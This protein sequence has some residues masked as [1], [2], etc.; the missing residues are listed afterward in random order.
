[1]RDRSHIP[2]QEGHT[3][4]DACADAVDPAPHEHHAEAIREQEAH[5]DQRQVRRRETQL[6]L[7]ERDQQRE[8]LPV[9]IIDGGGEEQQRTDGPAGACDDACRRRCGLRRIGH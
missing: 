4:P 9:E 6:I 3:Q 2:H 5:V 1:M 7:E 8:Q